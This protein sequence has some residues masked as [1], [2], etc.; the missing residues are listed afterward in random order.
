MNLQRNMIAVL[1]Q[2]GL[3]F[4]TATKSVPRSLKLGLCRPGSGLSETRWGLTPTCLT[5]ETKGLLCYSL[6]LGD[7][8]LFSF[9]RLFIP[10]SLLPTYTFL[11]SK[12]LSF[13][14]RRQPPSAVTPH[15]PQSLFWGRFA[16]IIL[17]LYSLFSHAW[18]SKVIEHRLSRSLLSLRNQCQDLSVPLPIGPPRVSNI[19]RIRAIRLR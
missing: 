1:H 12:P 3:H 17:S 16:S 11:R 2:I 10:R 8:V 9:L 18:S 5:P 14:P 13:Q 7:T 19:Y 4:E 15:P 6:P